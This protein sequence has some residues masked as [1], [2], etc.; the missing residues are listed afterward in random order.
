LKAWKTN[1]NKVFANPTSPSAGG[2]KKS[3]VEGEKKKGHVT[4]FIIFCQE[5]KEIY[6]L[7]N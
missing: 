2:K 6:K 1:P 5:K 7:T 3:K 4:S